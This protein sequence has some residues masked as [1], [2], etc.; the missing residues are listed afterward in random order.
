MNPEAGTTYE[1]YLQ[2]VRTQQ[3]RDR[4]RFT[5][6]DS[7]GD[8]PMYWAETGQ[9]EMDL[10][11]LRRLRIENQKPFTFYITSAAKAAK[12]ARHSYPKPRREWWN[13]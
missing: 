2:A 8:E 12:P 10:S 9:Q 5:G 11:F 6:R 4:D 7:H 3:E 1:D 13:R